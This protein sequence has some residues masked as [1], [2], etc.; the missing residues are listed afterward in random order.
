[1]RCFNS[2]AFS[3]FCFLPSFFFDFFSVFIQNSNYQRKQFHLHLNLSLKKTYSLS[4]SQRAHTNLEN[5]NSYKTNCLH[6][7]VP[8]SVECHHHC[9]YNISKVFRLT[10]LPYKS[11]DGHLDHSLLYSILKNNELN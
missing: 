2:D 5:C 11:K 10:V 8:L 1:M 6:Q 3:P 7:H 9:N 4:I